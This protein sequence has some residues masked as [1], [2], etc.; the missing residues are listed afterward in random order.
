[1]VVL[2]AINK[3]QKQTVNE[4]TIWEHGIERQLS[5]NI[6]FACR[7][8]QLS[9]KKAETPQEQGDTK[10]LFDPIPIGKGHRR[11]PATLYSSPDFK[12]TA[13]STFDSRFYKS[14]KYDVKELVKQPNNEITKPYLSS[15]TA[16]QTTGEPEPVAQALKCSDKPLE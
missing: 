10:Y 16:C 12:H 7:P 4:A 6:P 14:I 3:V 8:S 2:P 5:P 1:M 13:P 11:Q 9:R 15:D